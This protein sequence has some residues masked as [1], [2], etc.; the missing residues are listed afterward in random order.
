[1]DGCEHKVSESVDFGIKVCVECGQ[2][3]EETVI[4]NEIEHDRGGF[5]ERCG[6]S[7]KS[8]NLF[9]GDPEFSKNYLSNPFAPKNTLGRYNPRKVCLFIIPQLSFFFSF[10]FYISNQ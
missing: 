2:V 7:L 8:N 9:Q 4:R 1:M 10:S 6:T 5:N 3:L